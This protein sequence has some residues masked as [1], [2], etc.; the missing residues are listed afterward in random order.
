MK[1]MLRSDSMPDVRICSGA[2]GEAPAWED[3]TEERL[4]QHIR[5]LQTALKWVQE[6][7]RIKG[8]PK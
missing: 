3:C 5:T 2:P 1:V 6:Q 4:Q 7:K 8:T